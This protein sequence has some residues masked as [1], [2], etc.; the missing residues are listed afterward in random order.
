MTGAVTL[1]MDCTLSSNENV[2]VADICK[3]HFS[4]WRHLDELNEEKLENGC[5]E[6]VYDDKSCQ[7]N[8]SYSLPDVKKFIRR[9]QFLQFDESYRLA[10]YVMLWDHAIHPDSDY[11]IDDDKE[12]EEE[13]LVKASRIVIEMMKMKV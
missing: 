7:P 1:S 4:S 8:G 9:K 12:W 6:Y 10:F 3:L 13:D 11:D 5:G 2:S